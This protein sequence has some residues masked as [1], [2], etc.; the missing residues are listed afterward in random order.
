[1][2]DY[3]LISQTKFGEILKLEDLVEFLEFWHNINK[4]VNKIF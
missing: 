1:M 3:Y 4:Y 2:L